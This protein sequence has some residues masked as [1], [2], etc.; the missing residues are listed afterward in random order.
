MPTLVLPDDSIMTESAAMMIYL[1]DLHPE[2]GL[3]PATGTVER[4]RYLRW[5][6]FLATALY[7]SDLRLFYP[8]RYTVDGAGAEGIKARAHHTMM[9]EFAIYA[10]ALGEGP[11]LLGSRMSAV[12]IYA[13]MLC[14]WAPDVPALFAAHPMLKRMYEAVL[15]NEKVKT[16][17]GRNG[18]GCEEVACEL[19]EACGYAP[20]MLELVEEAFDEVTQTVGLPFDAAL[21][22]AVSLCGNMSA[23]VL[24][25]GQINEGL[26]VIATVCHEIAGPVE[27]SDQ[28]N[29]GLLVGGLPGVS[30]MRMGKPSP[31]TITLILVLSPPRERPMA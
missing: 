4:A 27:A 25:S 2:A 17:W 15:R 8:E 29:G 22:L 19:I 30:A 7:M 6:V 20:E 13:A 26:C 31:S 1:A 21:D 16:V 28:R 14:S 12:D 18:D 10:E 23:D 3:A 24:A 11:F 9:Q 5:M